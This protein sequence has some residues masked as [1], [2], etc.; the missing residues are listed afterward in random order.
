MILL[1]LLRDSIADFMSAVVT[2]GRS[3]LHLLRRMPVHVQ[4]IGNW[5]VIASL[6]GRAGLTRTD[7]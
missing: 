1:E 7:F 6:N 5:S 3:H 2:L 4:L